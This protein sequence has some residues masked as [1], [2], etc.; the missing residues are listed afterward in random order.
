M[1]DRNKWAVHN[2]TEQVTMLTRAVEERS[3]QTAMLHARVATLEVENS[4]LRAQN[5]ALQ[6]SLMGRDASTTPSSALLIMRRE[7]WETAPKNAPSTCLADEILQGFIAS[8]R[9]GNFLSATGVM[10]RAAAYSLKPKLCSLIEPDRSAEDDISNVVA[11]I[12][13]SY[14]EIETLPKQVAV[15]WNMAL[16]LKWMVLLDQQSWDLMPEWLHLRIYHS[17]YPNPMVPT[18]LSVSQFLIQTNPDDVSP[19]K[20]IWQDFGDENQKVTYAGLR[21]NAA[22]DAAGLREMLGLKEG[23]V[24]C[25]IATNSALWASLAHAVLWVGA[26]FSQYPRDIRNAAVSPMYPFD[27]SN[28]DNTKIPAG[29]CFSSGTSGKPK[30]VVL[31]HHN[32]IAQLLSVRATNPFTHTSTSREPFFPSFAHIYGIVSGVLAPAWIGNYVQP[33]RR[34]EYHPYL[35]RAAELKANILRLVP[36]TAVRMTKYP[37]VKNLNLSA[38]HTV[39]CS[40]SPLSSDTVV[41]LQQILSPEA[42]VLNGYGMREAT[43][44]LLRNTRSGQKGASVGKPAAGMEVRIVDENY[45]DVQAG[46]DGE[47]LI[48]GSSVFMEYKNNEAETAAAFRGGWMCTGDIVHVDQDGYFWLTGRKKELIKY[49]SHQI[50]P[51]ELEAVLLSHPSVTDAGV[52]GVGDK[53][54]QEEL[55]VGFVCLSTAMSNR[56]RSQTMERLSAF[57][58]ERVSSY[59]RLRGGLFLIESLPKNSS[60]KLLRRELVLLAERLRSSRARI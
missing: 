27:M 28:G 49:K 50:A 37:E 18:N 33:M 23:D 40:G 12:V 19:E 17:P 2:L 25:I 44:T 15:F 5:A 9:T 36:A 51:A 13:R 21:S 8:V 6:L 38:V 7:P 59:K 29:M 42:T 34:F 20:I 45:N 22:F 3:Q 26:C 47:C 55:P 43:V 4:Q 11:D 1:R 48:R 32:L 56:D 14:P 31:S 54:T 60:G 10:E 53:A 30:A 39:M 24:M 52:C 16:L 35:Q 58:N 46:V 41:A 57:M